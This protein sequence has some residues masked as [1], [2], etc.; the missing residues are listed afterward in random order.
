VAAYKGDDLDE[1]DLGV[2]QAEEKARP[3]GVEGELQEVQCQPAFGFSGGTPA[4]HQANTTI[5]R[6]STVQTGPNSQS[7]GVHDG[8]RIVGYHSR[9]GPM[10]THQPI[11]FLPKH[12]VQVARNILKRVDTRW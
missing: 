4:P 11:V 6:N 10:T 8:L 5:S 2:L 9:I 1:G 3:A 7:G 12:T